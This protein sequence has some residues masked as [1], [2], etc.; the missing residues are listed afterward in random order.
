MNKIPHQITLIAFQTNA[1]GTRSVYDIVETSFH[2][3]YHFARR[4][5]RNTDISSFIA[6]PPRQQ[7]GTEWK[8]D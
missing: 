7:T 2:Y 6:C 1:D 5:I 3:A 4:F 8:R